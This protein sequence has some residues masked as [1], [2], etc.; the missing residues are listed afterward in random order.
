MRRLS[1]FAK[2]DSVAVRARLCD[3]RLNSMVEKLSH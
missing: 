3:K 2:K 1:L